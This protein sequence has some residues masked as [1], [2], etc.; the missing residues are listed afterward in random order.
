[1][2]LHEMTEVSAWIVH[3][4]A[5]RAV[6]GLHGYVAMTQS[7]HI[8]AIAALSASTAMLNLRVL[9]LMN[10][11]QPIAEL[12]GRFRRPV[13][14]AV[15]V[16]LATGLALLL[17]EPKRSLTSQVFQL[18]MLML[19]VAILLTLFLQRLALQYAPQWDAAGRAPASAR[20]PAV[21]SL[22]LWVCIIF[23][24][25]WIAYAQY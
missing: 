22:L 11:S 20:V 21:L 3:T 19:V 10:R 17:A 6:Q 15:T 12:N 14:I 2:F 24:G 5:S 16:L 23:A 8:L 4:R 7:V 13:W 9:G 25:R 18:K 1:M